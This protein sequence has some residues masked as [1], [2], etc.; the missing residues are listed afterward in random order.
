MA[1][2]EWRETMRPGV[3][4]SGVGA[5]HTPHLVP[6]PS[7]VAAPLGLDQSMEGEDPENITKHKTLK[8]ISMH[9]IN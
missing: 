7:R 4:L 8:H 2:D 9:R 5:F 1:D 3:I 6:D